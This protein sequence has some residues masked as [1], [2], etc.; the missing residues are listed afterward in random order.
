VASVAEWFRRAWFLLNRRRLDEVLRQE[1]EAHRAMMERPDRFGSVLRLREESRDV[2]GWRWL[3]QLAQ[4]VRFGARTLLVDRGFAATAILILALATG[5]TTAIFSVVNGVI[6]KPLPF[7]APDR[8]V[9]VHGR[10]WADDR[11]ASAPDPLQGPVGSLELEAFARNGASFDGF[12]GYAVSVAYLEGPS[13]AERLAAVVADGTF[14]PLLGVAPLVGRTFGPRDAAEVAVISEGLW[15]RR[16]GRDPGLPGRTVALDGGTVTIV[17]VMPAT[18]QFPYRAGSTLPGAEPEVRTDVWRPLPPLRAAADGALR[19]GRVSVVAR[20]KPGVT[21]DQAAADL[22][23]VAGRVERDQPG[24]PGRRIGVRLERLTDAVL[25]PVRR[26]LWL[27][28]AGV[29]LVLV[30]ACANVANL[31]LART[32]A[33]T[34]EVATRAALGAGR[35]R[36]VRQFL[37]ESLLLALAGGLAGVL[38]ARWGT[39]LLVTIAE[40][41]IP[42]AHEAA[43]D[44]TAFAFLL[45]AC[46]ATAVLFGLAPALSASR[47]DVQSVTKEAGGHATQGRGV[48]RLRD[49]LVVIEVALAFVLAAGA[50]VVVREVVRLRNVDLG[51]VTENVLSLHVAPRAAAHDYYAIEQRVAALPGVRA[52]GFIQLMPLQNWGWLGAFSIRGRE[53]EGRLTSELRY[54]TPGYFAAMGI[55]LLS[56]RWLA[57]GDVEGAPRVI[58]VNEAL[59]RR[60]FRGEDPVGRELDRGTIV[61][62]VGDVRQASLDSPAEPAIF[63]PAAQNIDMTS[64]AG[65]SLV[66][67]TASDPAAMTA[68]IRDAV[69][70]VNP[71]LAIF[72]VKSMEEI[73]D[74]SLWQLR[75][76]R[77]LIGAFAGLALMLAAIGLYGVMSY[78][79]SARTKEFA[80]RLALGSA[81]GELTRLV[82]RRGVLLVGLGLIAGLLAALAIAPLVASVYAGLQP[83]PFAYAVVAALVMAVALV[84]CAFPARRVASVD[85]AGALRHE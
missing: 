72:N 31:L 81:P 21:I 57:A 4:D 75:L 73:L 68:A 66:V 61:G 49:A 14:F 80:V 43:L 69:R 38:V 40:S 29:G 52:A 60:Y 27:L 13:G 48:G 44:W 36:L 33:R 11:G 50:A 2:W 32:M 37:A 12:A 25:G 1:L 26:S 34:R 16:F 3:D 82:L 65:M 67:R 10:T 51:A 85:P 53:G 5:A 58:L 20:M 23:V 59:A 64:D 18:F 17:G 83:D 46:L 30:A 19:R 76:Y 74:D 42:R 28:F 84:A 8:L 55:P 7:A 22:R 54:V 56:G 71:A 62:I 24:A 35:A 70:A 63:Y 15:E 41:R 77:W 47:V 78:G 45:L 9:Q 79:V 6:L 39:R